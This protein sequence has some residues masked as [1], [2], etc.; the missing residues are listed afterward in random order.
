MENWKYLILV[1]NWK[2]LI[3]AYI[4]CFPQGKDRGHF[5]GANCRFVITRAVGQ[6]KFQ[7][8]QENCSWSLILVK[9]ASFRGKAKRCREEVFE[10]STEQ[11]L[12]F[13]S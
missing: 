2:Y 3:L 4:L 1:E 10:T 7:K 9:S 6:G 5:T 11:G 8:S 13:F 12:L